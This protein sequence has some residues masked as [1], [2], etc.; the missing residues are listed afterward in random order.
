MTFIEKFIGKAP[1]DVTR[2]DVERLVRK[3]IEENV[4]L[5]YKAIDILD[6]PKKLLKHICG[7]ANSKGGLLVVGVSELEDIGPNNEV[8]RVYPDKIT[9]SDGALKKEELE[10]IIRG[11]IDPDPPI[12]IVPVRRSK[13]SIQ[14]IF[15]IDVLNRGAIHVSEEKVYLRQDFRTTPLSTKALIQF[16]RYNEGLQKSATFR[17]ELQSALLYFIHETLF[18]LDP[19]TAEKFRDPEEDKTRKVMLAR[20]K[21]LMSM[22]PERMIT[23]FSKIPL[24]DFGKVESAFDQLESEIS[25]AETYSNSELSAEERD[26]LIELER[27][28][29]RNQ[30]RK[31]H[32]YFFIYDYLD[33]FEEGKGKISNNKWDYLGDAIR[34]S[35]DPQGVKSDLKRMFRALGD[36]GIAVYKM[37]MKLEEI[38]DNFGPLGIKTYDDPDDL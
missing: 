10:D 22:K 36:L 33:W 13:N 24:R 32:N 38:R 14:G 16:A 1:L 21:K 18:R 34:K 28:I 8:V 11:K 12:R 31:G 9:W 37:Q 6:E 4:T 3:K 20:F 35:G 30:D 2:S 7:L 17:R 5:D 27:E 29:N 15:L 23:A 19:S 26:L 25:V